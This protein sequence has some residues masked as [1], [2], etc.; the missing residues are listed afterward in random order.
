M[1]S[2]LLTHKNYDFNG[3]ISTNTHRLKLIQWGVKPNEIKYQLFSVNC[4]LIYFSPNG[5]KCIELI[6][7]IVSER[8]SGKTASALC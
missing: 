6:V 5:L 7:I 3:H 8:L 4:N 1:M 2:L